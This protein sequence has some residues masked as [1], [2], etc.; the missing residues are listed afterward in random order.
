MYG[1]EVLTAPS[2]EPVT[3]AELRTRLRLNHTA[4]DTDLAEFLS[5]AVEQ[6]EQDCNRPILST[7]YRQS[8]SRWPHDGIIVLGRG[9]VT[10]VSAVKS[11]A[12]DGSAEDLDADAWLAV[13]ST[14]PARVELAMIPVEVLTA[15]GIVRRPVGCVE[16]TAGWAS[17]AAVPALVKRGVKL[18]AAHFYE[19]REAY[20]EGKLDELPIGWWNLVNKFKLGVSGD[21]GQ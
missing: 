19:H 12:A 15:G 21:W 9:G 10:A 16:F 3:V 13:L 11:Y 8:L 20:R 17:A 5:A 18:L 1:V 14:P 7:T 6:F 4:E 2:A